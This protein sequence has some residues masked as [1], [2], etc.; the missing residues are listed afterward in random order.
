MKT[1]FDLIQEWRSTRADAERIEIQARK[2]RQQAAALETQ[3]CDALLQ[4]GPVV[5]GSELFLPPE[6]PNDQIRVQR[7]TDAIR[8]VLSQSETTN[9]KGGAA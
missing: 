8:V 7:V 3:V 1:L 9:P 2:T 4:H 5:A 6:S